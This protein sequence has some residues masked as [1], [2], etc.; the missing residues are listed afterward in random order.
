MPSAFSV[1]DAPHL[2]NLDIKMFGKHYRLHPV[3]DLKLQVSD[4]GACLQSQPAMY[5]FY[6][7]LR[8]LANTN[9]ETIKRRIEDRRAELDNTW[10]S[11]GYI[12]GDIKITEDSMRRGLR[13][14]NQL[15]AHADNLVLAQFMYDTLSSIVKAFEHRRDMLISLST[16]ANNST[17]HDR[18]VDVYVSGKFGDAA[19]SDQAPTTLKDKV[20]G[21]G[22]FP[23]SK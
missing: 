12:P 3:E 23:G 15:K 7:S 1:E 16:R 19:E 6:A 5:A 21:R 20:K 13:N 4:L 10:R 14:D 11:Q 8:D 22:A 18:D 9:V 17:F 2:A